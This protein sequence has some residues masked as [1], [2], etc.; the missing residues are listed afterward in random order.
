[1]NLKKELLAGI[2]QQGGWVNTHAHF[3]RAYSLDE[4]SVK[5]IYAPLK[6]KWE[7]VDTLK[8]SSSV[9]DV[10]ARMAQATELMLEQGV[11]AF[12]SFIDVDEA[13][14]EKSI[15]AAE[16]LRAE[17]GSKIRMKFVNQTLKGVLEKDARYWFD[18]A[19]EFTDIIGGLPAK[20]AGREEE[21]LDLLLSTGKR[22][23][24]RVHVHVDQFNTDEESETELLAQKVIEHD[25]Q[26]M[27][28]AIHCISLAAHPKAKRES[29]YELMREAQLSVISCPIAWIDH[30]R[31]ERLAPSHNAITPVDEMLEYGI[32]VALGTDNIVDVYKPFG[33]GDMWTEMKLLL[34]ACKIYKPELLIPIAT[35]N[36]LEVLG[37]EENFGRREQ[38]AAPSNSFKSSPIM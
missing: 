29:I 1:M 24:K 4:N 36:G 6:K 2:R 26:G 19:V 34:E 20:D 31:T 8:R 35:V 3:D 28:T 38:Q 30:P 23:N 21:H 32:R 18:R 37:L 14:G 5:E 13:I 25:M 27:V 7:I 22:L 17:Y 11:Q 15:L 9:E 12:G 33:D 16:K 10:Y